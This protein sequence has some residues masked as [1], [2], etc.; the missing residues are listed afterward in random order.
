MGAAQ[1]KPYLLKPKEAAQS[2]AI[3]ERTLWQLTNQ[4]DLPCVRIGRSVRYDP[5]DLACWIQQRK[6]GG[7]AEGAISES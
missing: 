6:S 2:L 1:M 5:A 4:G 3:S 7:K